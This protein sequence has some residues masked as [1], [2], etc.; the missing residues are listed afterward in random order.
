M[1]NHFNGLLPYGKRTGLFFAILGVFY[2]FPYDWVRTPLIY[3]PPIILLTQPGWESYLLAIIHGVVHLWFPFID[4]NGLNSEYTAFPDVLVHTL[5]LG[6]SMELYLDRPHTNYYVTPLFYIM[7]VGSLFNVFTSIVYNP[8]AAIFVY[9]SIFQALSSG[10]WVFTHLFYT[11]KKDKYYI[12]VGATA[13]FV[14]VLN[15]VLFRNNESIL[16]DAFINRYFET[17]FIIP[18]LF[19]YQSSN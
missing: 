7:Y 6:R 10:C 13:L 12:P 16:A 15:W 5:M 9:S 4:G 2:V 1:E 17:L 14:S 3:V 19:Y 18:T 11:T 8:D